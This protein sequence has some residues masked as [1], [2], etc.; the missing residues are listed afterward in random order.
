M[1]NNENHFIV[2]W[3]LII[4]G[5]IIINHQNNRR[6]VRKEIR[7]AITEINTGIDELCKAARDYHFS[8]A[9]SDDAAQEIKL[10]IKKISQKIRLLSFESNEITLSI[11]DLRKSITFYNFDSG[12][13]FIKQGHDSI[14][15]EDISLAEER[16]V[17][18][19]EN[20]FMYEFREKLHRKLLRILGL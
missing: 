15:L 7:A 11:I 16:L 6:E 10:R 9:H 19:L 20:H 4:A 8:T 18:A 14:I 17:D 2:S 13:R 1:I 12:A 5:W 3:V